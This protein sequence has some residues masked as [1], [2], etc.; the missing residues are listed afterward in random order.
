LLKNSLEDRFRYEL[1]SSSKRKKNKVMVSQ[2]EVFLQ[3][4]LIAAFAMIIIFFTIFY[5]ATYSIAQKYNFFRIIL[6]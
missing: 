1:F 4:L 5:N 6:F 2:Y 3:H